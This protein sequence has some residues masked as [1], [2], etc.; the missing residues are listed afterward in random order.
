MKCIKA[1]QHYDKL[2]CNLSV[3]HYTSR[4]LQKDHVYQDLF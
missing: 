3:L 1:N 4:F 2:F